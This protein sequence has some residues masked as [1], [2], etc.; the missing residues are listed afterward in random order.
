M[1]TSACF[2]FARRFAA[3]RERGWVVFSVLTGV[4][5][6]VSFGAIAAGNA[7]PV[8]VLSLYGAI[9]LAWGWHALASLELRKLAAGR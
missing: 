4:F 8:V 6:V 3:A 2:V 5:F 1:N 7:S 9:F